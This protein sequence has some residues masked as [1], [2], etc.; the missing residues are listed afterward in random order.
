MNLDEELNR[1]VTVF[2]AYWPTLIQGGTPTVLYEAAR[3]LPAGGGKRMRPALAMLACESVGGDLRQALPFAAALELMHNFTLVHDDIM[4]KSAVRRNLPA[5]HVRFG[6][7]TAIL[8]GDLLFAK[9]FQAMHGLSTSCPVFKEL[10]E[11]LVQCI[12]DIC[13]GQ[14]LDMEFEKRGTVSEEEYLDMIGKKT[15]VLFRLATKGGCRIGGGSDQ[16][17]QALAA[18][19]MHLGLSFQ[20]WDDFLDM[21]SSETV[22]GKDIGND[23]RNGKK[24]LIA[25]H[26]QHHASREQRR[27]FDRVY[28]N[29]K[30]SEKDIKAA[31]E[32]LRETGSIEYARTVALQ[33]NATAKEQ[34]QVVPKTAVRDILSALADYAISREK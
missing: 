3:H 31:V 4:D 10:D 26:C 6:E 27:A 14:Q 18:Y 21:I 20:I 11:A 23:L 29:L 19:G 7:P 22:L 30:A 24:T 2:E 28:G 34:L 17:V 33:H 15:G 9:S 32:V 12:L 5:V 16:E 1:R 25:V 13:E 8:A